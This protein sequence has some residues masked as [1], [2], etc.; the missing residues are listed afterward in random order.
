MYEPAFPIWRKATDF[1]V[2]LY[3]LTNQFPKDELVGRINQLRAAAVGIVLNLAEGLSCEN[4]LDLQRF[5]TTSLKDAHDCI[6]ELQIAHRLNLCPPR[7]VE[8]LI[9]QA[10]E[11]AQSLSRLL[12]T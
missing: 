6:E 10:E 4:E 5:L 1:L 7:E 8:S 3:A 2:P 12:K 9:A 11:I